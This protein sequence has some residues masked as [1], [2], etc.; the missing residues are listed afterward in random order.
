MEANTWEQESNLLGNTDLIKEFERAL[1][2]Q[3][4]SARDILTTTSKVLLH[5]TYDPE[6]APTSSKRKATDEYMN[7]LPQKVSL[8]ELYILD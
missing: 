1:V 7:N 8:L 4:P 3:N 6:T 5:N 2:K